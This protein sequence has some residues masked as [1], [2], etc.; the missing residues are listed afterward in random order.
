[1]Y[2]KHSIV[3]CLVLAS[4]PSSPLTGV[5]SK[6]AQEIRT[7]H[8][9]A[10]GP[11]E[12][13]IGF[14][15]PDSEV[16]E[17]AHLSRMTIDK[18]FHGDLEGTGKGEMIASSDAKPDPKGSGAYVAM[19]RVIGSLKGRKGSLV[20]HHLGIMRKGVPELTILVVPGSGT[21]EL[22]GLSGKMNVI[23]GPGGEHSYEFD[24]TFE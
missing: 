8:E 4:G 1:M 5:Q 21:G 15:K 12:V 14:Q 2:L 3:L 19:E 9:R 6:S 16:A 17:T 23:I 13:K 20:L 18:Q 11:F 10:T 22:A 7:M 24:Y